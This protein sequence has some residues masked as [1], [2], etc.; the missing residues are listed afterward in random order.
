MIFTQ[1]KATTTLSSCFTTTNGSAVVTIAFS[2]AHNISAKDIVLLDN[3]S[4]ITNSNFTASDFDDKKFMV[5]SVPS[6]LQV[7]QLQCLQ[8]KQGSGATTS[9]G[10]RVQHYYPVGPA[11]QLPGLG[12][13]LGQWSG[14]VA[15]EAVTSLTSGINAS[16]TTGIQLNDASQF[17]TSGTN[18]VQIGTEEISY[19]GISSG[20]LTG[21]TRGVRNTTAASHNAGVAVTNSSDYIGW[22]EAASGD[23]VIDP[24]LW[25]IDNFGDKYY[26]TNT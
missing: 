19:T 22:G 6:T 20:V 15:G 13:G 23:L 26:C 17:P 1:L 21:V 2:G 4:T 3:F 8:T 11:E 24:G 18:F 10:I 12:W 5:T 14:T 16:Q 7:L 9:G 25:S